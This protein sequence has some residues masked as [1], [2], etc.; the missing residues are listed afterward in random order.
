MTL[1][2]NSRLIYTRL[3]IRFVPKWYDKNRVPVVG[4]DYIRQ[5][6]KMVLADYRPKLLKEPGMI[7]VRDFLQN[8]M[9]LDA[10]VADIWQWKEDERIAAAA[11]F[12]DTDRF[13]IV[14]ERGFCPR[15]VKAE[16]GTVVFDRSIVKHDY[17][18]RFT[19]LHEAAH[20]LM[21]SFFYENRD[22]SCTRSMI[23]G[24]R[25]L[26]TP[27]DF[28]EHQA[29]AFAGAILMPDELF[30]DTARSF[31]KRAGFGDGIWVRHTE[32]A[33]LNDYVFKEFL[34]YCRERFGVSH[35]AA[36]VQLKNYGLL[37]DRYEKEGEDL[38]TA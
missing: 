1:D 23:F 4:D 21:H 22:K 34:V 38:R 8:Y 25:A 28:L 12:K 9:K 27:G 14:S 3:M 17:L 37:E 16:A 36:I 13:A 18:L 30:I 29:N 15:F 11:L 24:S 6:A 20:F 26:I 7:D 19:A 31:F 2:I 33:R 35:S 32:K 5:Y 10:K